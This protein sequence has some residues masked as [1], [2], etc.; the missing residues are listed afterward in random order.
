MMNKF[1]KISVLTAGLV[2]PLALLA[3][4]LVAW[5]YKG[6]NPDN[7]DITAGLAYLRPILITSFVV[8]GLVWLISLVTGILALKNARTNELGRVGLLLLV[9]VTVVSLCAAISAGK[10]SDAEDAYRDQKATQ[11]FDAFKAD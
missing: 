9:L 1:G 3:G 4:N 5:Y 11:F 8:Y 6:G 7:V 2:L 10:V